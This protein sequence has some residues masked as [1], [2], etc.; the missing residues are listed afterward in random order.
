M[1]ETVVN[2]VFKA[3]LQNET[4]DTGSVGTFR[5][6]PERGLGLSQ[7]SMERSSYFK[8]SLGKVVVLKAATYPALGWIL[9]IV[10]QRHRMKSLLSQEGREGSP[11]WVRQLA[12]HRPTA[13]GLGTFHWGCRCGISDRSTL[14]EGLHAEVGCTHSGWKL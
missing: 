14:W 9:R 5:G 12:S 3:K 4:R 2:E 8:M 11:Q 7:F 6:T 10:L 1:R 13:L